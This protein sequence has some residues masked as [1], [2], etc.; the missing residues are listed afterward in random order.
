M[1]LG[2]RAPSAAPGIIRRSLPLFAILLVVLLTLSGTAHALSSS[3]ARLVSLTNSSRRSRGI[4]SLVVAAD[5]AAKAHRH[6]AAMAGAERAFHS[7]DLTGYSSENVAKVHSVDEA[8]RLF[9]SSSMHRANIL[10]PM[11][12]VIGA[13]VVSRGGWLYV[14]EIFSR[15][16][17]PRLAP[18]ASRSRITAV[19]L[20][21]RRPVRR[22]L[23]PP[24]TLDVLRRLLALDAG[25]LPPRRG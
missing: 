24:R 18:R 12:T 2:G 14:T 10:D 8:H 23:A 11:S 5:L 15:R 4:R 1:T 25:T 19:P 7:T 13:G 3:E 16:S 9:M 17:V 21:P 22:A 6:S 20:V